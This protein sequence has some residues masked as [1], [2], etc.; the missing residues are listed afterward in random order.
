VSPFPFCPQLQLHKT[1]SI[2]K[3]R[4]RLITA[5]IKMRM[6][7]GTPAKLLLN[8]L[9]TAF[10]IIVAFAT[11]G[12]MAQGAAAECTIAEMNSLSGNSNF[13]ECA[14]WAKSR[15]DNVADCASISDAECNCFP[16]TF[17]SDVMYC[18]Y[19]AERDI[20]DDLLRCGVSQIRCAC[21]GV[22]GDT[23]MR[24]ASSSSQIT[25]VEVPRSAQ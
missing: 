2:K 14:Q 3:E 1:K 13:S 10:A 6:A 25:V 23:Y 12:V 24:H 20:Q 4:H 8:S 19:Y 16:E 18:L 9:L 21:D 17:T 15:T 5:W 11:V 22:L 7:I